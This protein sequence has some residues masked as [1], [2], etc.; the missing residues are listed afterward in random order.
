LADVDLLISFGRNND[1]NSMIDCSIRHRRD[2][3]KRESIK[4]PVGKCW[5]QYINPLCL[6]LRWGYRSQCPNHSF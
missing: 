3:A 2:R 4:L 1:Y 6:M 5:F